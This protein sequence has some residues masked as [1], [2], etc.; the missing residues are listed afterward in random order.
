LPFN[1]IDFRI[2]LI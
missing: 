2:K 1:Q